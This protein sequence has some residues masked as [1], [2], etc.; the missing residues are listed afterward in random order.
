MRKIINYVVVCVAIAALMA[1]TAYAKEKKNGHPVAQPA[2]NVDQAKAAAVAAIPKLTVGKPYTK[3]GKQEILLE[4][5]LNLDG[6]VVGKVRFNPTNG[7]ILM[8]GQRAMA[9]KLSVKPEDAGKTLQ[10]VLPKMQAGAAWI[11]KDGQWKVPLLYQGVIISELR[12]DGKDASVLPDWK[13][14]KDANLFG[15]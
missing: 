15:K 12:V 3:P 4:A 8:K 9:Q 7:E 10:S 1:G 14:S 6:A 11:G 13:A 2:T 5:P